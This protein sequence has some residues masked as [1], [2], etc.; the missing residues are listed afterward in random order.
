MDLNQIKVLAISQRDM[1][2]YIDAEL[3]KCAPDDPPLLSDLIIAENSGGLQV[4]M[5]L[6]QRHKENLELPLEQRFNWK[7]KVMRDEWGNIPQPGEDYILTLK[8]PYVQGGKKLTIGQINID[9]AT[10]LHDEKWLKH[11]PYKV[12]AKGCITCGYE[13]AMIFI[14]KYGMHPITGKGGPPLSMHKIPHSENP[15]NAPDGMQKHAWYWRVQEVTK[16]DYE[17]MPDRVPDDRPKRGR[18]V[19]E[20]TNAN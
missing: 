18:P 20:I 11:I 16:A 2:N 13:H 4:L 7:L 12:D 8:K 17:K 10:G 1:N 14:R 6:E 9:I 3:D 15:V 5:A 19:K